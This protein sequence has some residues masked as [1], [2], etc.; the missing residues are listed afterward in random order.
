MTEETTE[1]KTY[2]LNTWLG[3]RD[4]SALKNPETGD[5]RP[6]LTRFFEELKGCDT[7]VLSNHPKVRCLSLQVGKCWV[8]TFLCL[9]FPL[10]GDSLEMPTNE[11]ERGRGGERGREGGAFR[12]RNGFWKELDC[13]E[14]TIALTNNTEN[15]TGTARTF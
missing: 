2:P 1:T 14:Q 15:K 3:F 13:I 11:T 10:T 7:N 5:G 9:R 4:A 6:C 8:E 12:E